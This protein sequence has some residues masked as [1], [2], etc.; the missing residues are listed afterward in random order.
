MTFPCLHC[1]QQLSVLDSIINS[2]VWQ[3]ERCHVRYGLTKQ[4]G[5]YV[6]YDFTVDTGRYCLVV[7]LASEETELRYF[8]SDSSNFD[9]RSG[10]LKSSLVMSVPY[11]LQNINP[12]N[13]WEKIQTLLTFS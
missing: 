11:I 3:C 12:S 7:D 6:A 2:F 8:P 9:I 4:Y 5:Y 1:Q 10:R 13:L